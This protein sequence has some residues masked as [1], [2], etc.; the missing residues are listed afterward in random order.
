[1]KTQR[2]NTPSG[3]IQ[4]RLYNLDEAAVYLGRT[5]WSVRELIWAGKI[6]EVRIGKRVQLD[7]RDM[8][9]FIERS[10]QVCN[11]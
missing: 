4:K 11:L 8:D 6:P 2:I 3:A 7:I 5:K 1:M 10:K 9:L